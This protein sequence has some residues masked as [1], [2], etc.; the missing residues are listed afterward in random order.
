MQRGQ[1]KFSL[2]IYISTFFNKKIGDF[3]MT[4]KTRLIQRGRSISI[5]SIHI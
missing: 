4:E 1:T 2:F 5:F 3:S